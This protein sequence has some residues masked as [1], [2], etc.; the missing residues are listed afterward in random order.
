MRRVAALAEVV[1]PVLY[2]LSPAAGYMTGQALRFDGG[3]GLAPPPGREAYPSDRA[4]DGS[5]KIASRYLATRSSRLAM[6]R[7]VAATLSPRPSA[8]L[9]H[10]R[11]KPRDVSGNEPYL[12]SHRMPLTYRAAFRSV[13]PK[14][15]GPAG[16]G[17]RPNP[18]PAT[19]KPF[20]YRTPV[21]HYR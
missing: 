17:R 1:G 6:S 15:V 2:L 9:A 8:A 5:A 14:G 20:I 18:I 19:W 16:P 21:P 4:A 12:H 10:S 7:A 3:A 13:S 11:P